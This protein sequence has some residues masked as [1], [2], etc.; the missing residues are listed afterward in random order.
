MSR[1]DCPKCGTENRIDMWDDGE[2][3]KCDNKYWWE[4]YCDEDN[5]DCWG[6]LVWLK[7]A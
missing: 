2:C 7:F 1:Y 5:E 4:E 3:T 6:E